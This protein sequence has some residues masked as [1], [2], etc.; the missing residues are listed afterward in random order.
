[1]KNIV[2]LAGL[3]VVFAVPTVSSA[4]TP[5]ANSATIAELQ[6]LLATLQAQLSVQKG[7]TAPAV[8]TLALPNNEWQYDRKRTEDPEESDY[9]GEDERISLF[10]VN[11]GKIRLSKSEERDDTD[12]KRTQNAWTAFK[13]VAGQP[14]IDTYVDELVT[15][16][17]IEDPTLGQVLRFPDKKPTWT[18]VSNKGTGW[19]LILNV[20]YANMKGDVTQKEFMTTL[21]HE[22]AHLATLNDDQTDYTLTYAQKCKSK[23][24]YFLPLTKNRDRGCT[25]VDSY[26]NAFAKKFW[27]ESQIKKTEIAWEDDEAEEY[28]EANTDKFV[29]WYATRNPMEDLAESF[30]DFIVMKKP[31][32]TTI[33]DQKILFFYNYPELVQSRTEMRARIAIYFK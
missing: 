29:T 3:L 6:K 15:T 20:A 5:S 10:R 1:M 17:A 19:G 27:T 7:I 30:T 26:M 16:D 24:R 9:D 22:Y 4:Q 11:G 8:A 14:F 25:N 33:K 31:T 2:L 13:A 18:T 28:Y 21:I 12:E 32:G 23:N